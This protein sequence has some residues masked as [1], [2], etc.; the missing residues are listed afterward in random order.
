MNASRPYQGTHR[1]MFP[2]KALKQ[3]PF[4]P[5]PASGG[6]QKSWCSLICSCIIPICLH[7]HMNM[8][9]CV[10]LYHLYCGSPGRAASCPAHLFS[11]ASG[12]WVCFVHSALQDRQDRN[13]S[14]PSSSNYFYNGLLFQSS[15]LLRKKLGAGNFLPMYH[16]AFSQGEG[17]W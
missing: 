2:L 9:S 14:L 10:G 12:H 5:L 3:N 8:L 4:L 6:S 13:Q 1:A 15:S 11:L 7:L 16:A 17:L